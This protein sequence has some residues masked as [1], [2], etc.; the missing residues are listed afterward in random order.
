MNEAQTRRH[1]IDT[2]LRLAGWNLQ[3]PSQVVE[4]LD[5]DLAQ[6]GRSVKE[7]S[8]DRPYAG[9]QFTDYAL[10]LRGRP[11]LVV[12]AKRTSKNARLGQEQALIYAQNLQRIHAGPLPLISF[13]NGFDTWFWDSEFYPPQR[14]HGF[15]SLDDLMWLTER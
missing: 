14:V 6:T 5:I 8:P 9:H 7:A 1:P 12:E 10:K 15:P 4:E 3:D 13:T 2:S 11:D